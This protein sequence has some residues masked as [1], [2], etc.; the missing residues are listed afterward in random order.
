MTDLVV[1]PVESRSEQRRFI[2][3]PWDIY[4]GDPIWIPPLIHSQKGLL[5]FLPH[6]FYRQAESRSFLVR[7]GGTDVG[8]IT[9]V[10]DRAHNERHKERR[11]FFGFFECRDDDDAARAL[12]GA[13]RDWLRGRGMTCVRGPANPSLNYEAGLLVDAFDKPPTF[14][15]TYNPPWYPRLVEENGFV[16]AH[17]MY[18]YWGEVPMLAKQDPKLREMRDAVLE[19]FGV[20]LRPLD[21]SRFE[22]DVKLYFRIYNDSMRANWGFVPFSEAEILH[23]AGELRH[24][25]V[26]DLAVVAEVNGKAVGTTFALLD[27]NP[28][29]RM[30]G[31]RLLPF[32]WA[33]LLWNRRAIKNV[34]L[35]TANVVPEYQAWGI[36][37]VLLDALVPPVLDWGI[38]EAEF[39]WILES[40][41]LT[42]G[43]LERGGAVRTKT[44]RMYQDDPP[45]ST[46]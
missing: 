1:R 45:P 20:K 33:R 15:T 41:V 43:S 2:R 42:R 32:G 3:L 28:R 27:Y 19:R 38:R 29:I 9:A 11:G 7:R 23:L 39:S 31:G 44:W 26:R 13:A 40:N 10:V 12:F 18:A 5:G 36:G 4:R 21:K 37:L 17:D 22:D 24:L 6:P 8:R 30:I 16:K 14:M 35:V 46:T 34:R 25:I